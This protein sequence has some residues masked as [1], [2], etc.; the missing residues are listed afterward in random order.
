MKAYYH[1]IFWGGPPDPP[2]WVG[3]FLPYPPCWRESSEVKWFAAYSESCGQPC[4][5]QLTPS[6]SFSIKTF[7]SATSFLDCLSLALNTSL[8]KKTQCI[9]LHTHL[10]DKWL[11]PWLMY[12]LLKRNAPLICLF[13]MVH[14]NRQIMVALDPMS[15]R[16]GL[17]PA[18]DSRSRFFFQVKASNAK[19][20]WL[21][22]WNFN[23]IA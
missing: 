15:C 18:L 9:K 21:W 3:S 2:H 19:M 20:N 13:L 10:R 12:I 23:A 1:K 5:R 22:L 8:K 16:H 6:F 14:L 11:Q 7:L 4:K 17:K